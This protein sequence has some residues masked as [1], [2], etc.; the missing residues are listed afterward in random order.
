MVPRMELRH[1]NA[2]ILL[3]TGKN[4]AF[5]VQGGSILLKIFRK[6]RQQYGMRSTKP[7]M[8]FTKH[9]FLFTFEISKASMLFSIEDVWVKTK[10]RNFLP[11]LHFDKVLVFFQGL[12]FILVF[13]NQYIKAAL[14]L[15]K[16]ILFILQRGRLY[17]GD[18]QVKRWSKGLYYTPTA[19]TPFK[20]LSE[21][22]RGSSFK[23]YP[24]KAS[25]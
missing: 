8:T 17:L 2:D 13:G 21:E 24:Q 25:D 7:R 3:M 9:F 23:R 5:Q 6:K 15:Q 11:C 16:L 4:Q 12:V 10:K 22:C 20:L 1:P 19:Y 18:S 14:S